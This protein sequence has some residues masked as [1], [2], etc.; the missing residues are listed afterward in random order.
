MVKS[1]LPSR[2]LLHNS[3][4]FVIVPLW[5]RLRQQPQ[6]QP[7]PPHQPQLPTTTTTT[8]TQP[9]QPPQPPFF[10][11]RA[12]RTQRQR[13]S[14]PIRN[15]VRQLRAGDDCRKKRRTVPHCEEGPRP[16]TPGG[17]RGSHGVVGPPRQ[18]QALQCALTRH[19]TA[20]ESK[21]KTTA[22]TTTTTKTTTTTTKT[23]NNHKQPTTKHTTNSQQPTN[24]QTNK[25]TNQQ[26]NK[27]QTSHRTSNSCLCPGFVTLCEYGFSGR[28]PAW[29]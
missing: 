11:V 23:I 12:N 19:E 8:T 15:C 5:S 26:T 2:A 4:D 10:F 16:H 28:R 29:C 24:Q 6:P 14:R 20:C 18:T 1:S 25:P 27:Q 17:T 13:S 9:Q 22:T 7:Q 21:V 3:S